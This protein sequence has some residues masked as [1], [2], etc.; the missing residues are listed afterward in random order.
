MNSLELN[1]AQKLEYDINWLDNYRGKI[2]ALKKDLEHQLV[3]IRSRMAALDFQDD[4]ITMWEAWK[5][6]RSINHMLDSLN[7][8]VQADRFLV[9]KRASMEMLLKSKLEPTMVDPIKIAEHQVRHQHLLEKLER[10]S[11]PDCEEMLATIEQGLTCNWQQVGS[12][13]N[14]SFQVRKCSV[15]FFCLGNPLDSKMKKL[16]IVK[17]TETFL[18]INIGPSRYYIDPL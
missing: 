2:N 16:K 6:K 12:S 10:V 5:P 8:Y 18:K 4:W 1:G 3:G 14:P 11:E 7:F 15:L 9:S 17:N 13:E